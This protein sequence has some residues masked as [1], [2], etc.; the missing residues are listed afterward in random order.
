MGYFKD[1][2]GVKCSIFVDD[3]NRQGEKQQVQKWSN[4]LGIDFQT[5]DRTYAI[6]SRGNSYNTYPVK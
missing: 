2:L 1:K 6:G 3:V 4:E 5:K